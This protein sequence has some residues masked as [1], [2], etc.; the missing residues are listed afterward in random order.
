MKKF[1]VVAIIL[2]VIVGAIALL[3]MNLE[4]IVNK[5][6]DFI[7]TRAETAL[8]RKV[9]IGD[10]GVTLR[11][12]LGVRLENFVVADDP[13]FSSEPFVTAAYL[14]VNAKLLPLLK[15]DFQIKRIVL[16]DP[17]IQI[18]RNKQGVFNFNSFS[19]AGESNQ[20]SQ[21]SVSGSGTGQA[22]AAIPLV[23]GIASIE[24]GEI[25]YVDHAQELD[26]RVQKIKTSVKDLDLEKP[27]DLNL[28]AAFLSDEKNTAIKG[29]FGPVPV[30]GG[31]PMS[32]PFELEIELNPI[33]VTTTL[34]AFKQMAKSIPPDVKIEGP[35][36]LRT[37]VKGTPA[38]MT[39]Q[40]GLNG[41]DLQVSGPQ[42]FNKPAG[43]PLAIDADT[44]FAGETLKI[45]NASIIFGELAASAKGLYTLGKTPSIDVTVDARDI[46]LAGWETIVPMVASYKL[47]GNAALTARI[48]GILGEGIQPDI[49]GTVKLT[50]A[51]ATLPQLMKPLTEIRTEIAFAKDKAEI[52]QMSF[53]LGET[54]VEGKGTVNGFDPPTVEYQATS[55]QAALADIRPPQPNLKKPEVLRNV[56]ASGRMIM[57]E[58]PAGNG[59][60]K[61]A[62][63]TISDIDYREL[64]ATYTMIGK[65][66]RIDNVRLRALDGTLTGSGLIEAGDDTNSFDLRLKATDVDVI[67]LMT[68]LPGSVRQSL[69]G[70]ANLNL[71]ISGK[72]KEWEDTQ[73]TLS[74]D[75]LAEIFEGE[76][77]DINIANSILDEISS[78]TGMSNLVPNAV[79]QKYPKVFAE[80]NTLI[81]N[82]NSDF[83][84]DNG[85]ILARNL[86]LKHEDYKIK[87]KGAIGFDRSLD[88]TATFTISKRLT[89]DLIRN[90]KAISYLTNERG[91][92]EV[93]VLLGGNISGIS[94]RPDSDY[95][96][97]LVGK[98]LVGDGL[99][100]LKNKYLKDLFP[101]NKQAKPDTSRI[102]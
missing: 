70:K 11:G 91:E 44:Q 94:V 47:S 62:D 78:Y 65:K 21:A 50:D 75:G 7:L 53:R 96:K 83:V 25:H 48:K 9:S 56:R 86:V 57:G 100:K 68:A 58:T 38:E 79:K 12:G 41:A 46:A 81:E 66:T 89:D 93:P 8:G 52:K 2:V 27:I 22:A 14:Q 102:R 33:D 4:G 76:L 98:A 51:A 37:A 5:N 72:G 15:K 64:D 39:I 61:S 84:V 63:G 97:D 80:K 17:V 19:G 20:A 1:L 6:K 40:I 99:D 85:R 35:L 3:V 43:V 32:T 18:I 16:R 36:A 13:D 23:V 90:Y 77:I 71:N 95:I 28:E 34:G 87:G 49:T 45:D 29:S 73:K 55:S 24:N 31:D 88:M 101:S 60:L 59:V 92:V 42:G 30:D 54:T 74:G 26:L 67:Q 10:I 82:L 69:R